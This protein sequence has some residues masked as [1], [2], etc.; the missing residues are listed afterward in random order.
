MRVPLAWLRDY[1]DLPADTAAT[2]ATLARLG[3]PVESVE[4]RPTITQVV[5][6]TITALDKHPNADRLQVCT[7]DIGAPAALTIATAATNVAAGQIVPVALIGAQLPQLTIAP[8]T[9]RGIESQGMLCSAQEL[10]LPGEWFEDGIMQLDDA[11][12]NGTDVVQYFGLHL[13][14]LDI[15]IGANRGDVLSLVGIAREIAAATHADFRFPPLATNDRAAAPTRP[16]QVSLESPDVRRYVA[17][18][19]GGVAVGRAPSAIRIRLALAGQRP[20]NNLVDIS[21]FVMLELGQP[22]HFFDAE[23]I[24]DDRIIVRDA[25]DGERLTTLDGTERRLDPTALVIADAQGATGLA[26]L[27]GGMVSEVSPAT[28]AILIES[29]NSSDERETRSA[30]RSIDPQ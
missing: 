25:R 9:M 13:P 7:I 3:F 20:I 17:V 29:A 16:V 4:T 24:A 6:G 27:M 22:L 18:P 12:P 23:R 5:V 21:N 26:G 14:V 15:E 2:V 10:G 11:A 28:H 8:R 30:D 19:V 1:V